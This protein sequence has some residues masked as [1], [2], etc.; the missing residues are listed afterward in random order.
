[1][2][3]YNHLQLYIWVLLTISISA[4]AQNDREIKY[5]A[6]TTRYFQ[7]ENITDHIDTLYKLDTTL[8]QFHQYD[9]RYFGRYPYQ[10][11]GVQGTAA[12]PLN[13]DVDRIPGTKLGYDLYTPYSYQN[14]DVQYYDTYSP[15]SQIEFI[16]SNNRILHFEG[17]FTR[18]FGSN[19]NAGFKLKRFTAANQIGEVSQ[20][21]KFS[22][23]YSG[24]LFTSIQSN[25]QRY[26][27]LGNYRY[28][29]MIVNETG[30]Y[31]LDSND[32]LIDSLFGEIEERA[33]NGVETQDRRNDWYLYQEYNFTA[34]SSK[35]GFYIYNRFDKLNQKVQIKDD[36]VANNIDFY[37][38]VP[39]S[40]TSNI[41]D[42]IVFREYKN[43][44]GLKYQDEMI[45]ASA[46]YK[47]RTYDF[48]IS[49]S[50]YRLDWQ[51]ENHYG[52]RVRIQPVDWASI[53]LSY[54]GFTYKNTTYRQLEADLKSKF[55]DINY[56]RGTNLISLA[57]KNLPSQWNSFRTQGPE[58]LK[59]T[60]ATTNFLV[61]LNYPG[62]QFKASLAYQRSTES[63]F[64]YLDQTDYQ[65]KGSK[66]G[67]STFKG[68]YWLQLGPFHFLGDLTY[69]IF[70]DENSPL[71]LPGVLANQEVYFQHYIYRK[72][73]LYQIG[74]DVGYR[75]SFF[76]DGYMPIYFLYAVQNDVE[77]ADYT[78]IDFFANFQIKQ[79]FTVSL[80]IP[81]LNQG[82]GS[83]Q[84][85]QVT[86]FYL[87]QDRTFE[88]GIKWR[89][90]D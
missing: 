20:N 7:A 38:F 3:Y 88:V 17:M 50:T 89:F 40:D 79:R 6:N 71:R 15:F 2:R 5:D 82:F 54:N 59:T 19:L 69:N 43:E 25:N 21:A 73:V 48:Q 16:Q 30:G 35:N 37:R 44:I 70:D 80:R 74:F 86:P 87:G 31:F 76:A 10:T 60:N 14:E 62:K 49:D 1:M 67:L 63:N 36:E 68:S 33:L 29:R 27:L 55:V 75:S 13:Y 34:D 51:L 83:K 12:K 28:M 64:R 41:F 72:K 9:F 81:H 85:Y 77:L 57:D 52:S 47:V 56:Y 39:T 58:S 84:G 46:Y 66:I 4:V 65:L 61:K 45:F 8:E 32:V 26:H 78:V 11:L 24:Q 90:Y 22:D 53:R 23:H 42:S 18:N